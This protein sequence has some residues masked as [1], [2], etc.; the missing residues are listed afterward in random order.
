MSQALKELNRSSKRKKKYPTAHNN[1]FSQ[2]WGFWGR[3]AIKRP[4]FIKEERYDY[5]DQMLLE[6]YMKSL[7][8]RRT[9]DQYYYYMLKDTESRD[10]DQVVYR[11]VT[12]DIS[13]TP[14]TMDAH[15]IMVDQLWL[16]IINDGG[17]NSLALCNSLTNLPQDAIISSFPETWGPD[18]KHNVLGRIDRYLDSSER[19][20]VTSTSELVELI[21]IHA[22]NIFDRSKELPPKLQFQDFFEGTIG[23]LVKQTSLICIF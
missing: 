12:E 15:V 3:P 6:G 1:T 21:L 7:H 5:H 22:L 8:P 11:W 18:S 13:E 4:V 16:W 10:N 2:F 14:D 9:L 19:P 20:P 23:N 17:K